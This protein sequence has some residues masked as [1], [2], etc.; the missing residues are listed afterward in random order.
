MNLNMT[1]RRFMPLITAILWIFAASVLRAQNDRAPGTLPGVEVKEWMIVVADPYRPRASPG[2]LVG[3]SLPD[4]ISDLRPKVA[5]AKQNEPSPIGLIRFFGQTDQKITVRL[6][7]R[8]GGVFYG[9][10]PDG[11]ARPAEL[12][13]RDL[14]LDSPRRQIVPLLGEPMDQQ[15]AKW[16]QRR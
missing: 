10:W 8:V 1:L 15:P 14:T 4:F 13:W 5:P 3:N 12:L 9:S 6:T 11:R 16:K 7:T 2:S